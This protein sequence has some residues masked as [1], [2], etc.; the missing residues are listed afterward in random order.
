M[1]SKEYELM[2]KLEDTHWWY[3]G[4]RDFLN[5][6]FSRYK[7]IMP[8]KP[9]I[10]D[11][12]CGTGAN[13]KYM[14]S[15]FPKGNFSGFDV[16]SI[17][18]RNAIVKCPDADIYKTSI[19]NPELKHKNYDLITILDVLYTTGIN[20]SLNGLKIILRNLKKNGFIILHNPA[21]Q[22]L[23]SEHDKAVHTQERYTH[24]DMIQLCDELDLKPILIGYR[25][26]LLFPFLLL[27]RLPRYLLK[28]K[29]IIDPKS[30]VKSVHKLINKVFS[31]LIKIENIG[32]K[33]GIMYPY[34]SSIFVIATKKS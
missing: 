4:L 23:Y 26:F 16:N 19:K 6:F 24:K 10:L 27:H 28:R 25:N 1:N 22:W 20:N 9:F 8:Q 14:K 18:L 11:V 30:D 2:N 17:A 12:G 3:I 29:K 32:L 31:L 7:N 33:L 13:L 34:G 15:F 21:Y 5:T